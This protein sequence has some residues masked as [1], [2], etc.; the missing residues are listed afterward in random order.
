[1]RSIC[2]LLEQYSVD[3]SRIGDGTVVL[4]CESS[5]LRTDRQD[6]RRRYLRLRFGIRRQSIVAGFGLAVPRVREAGKRTILE[7]DQRPTQVEYG[8]LVAGNRISREC[9]T[10]LNGPLFGYQCSV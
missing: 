7:I 5:Q 10:G 4:G 3:R 6:V 2:G 8:L 1:L 9:S